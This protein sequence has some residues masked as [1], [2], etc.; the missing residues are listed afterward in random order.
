MQR[1][2]LMERED[3]RHILERE[4]RVRLLQVSLGDIVPP[5]DQID[6]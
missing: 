5:V 4:R 3:I 6:R 2:R 1:Q